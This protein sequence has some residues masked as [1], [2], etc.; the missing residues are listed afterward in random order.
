MAGERKHSDN[1]R[2]LVALHQA[3]LGVAATTEKELLTVL[4]QQLEQILK[5]V[6][7]QSMELSNKQS[8]EQ[9]MLAKQEQS[10]PLHNRNE[11]DPRGLR[12]VSTLV[13]TNNLINP[14]H[15]FSLEDLQKMAKK[16]DSQLAATNEQVKELKEKW[17]SSQQAKPASAGSKRK[18]E[19]EPLDQNEDASSK[20]RRQP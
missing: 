4:A 11:R 15:S 16:L 18:H 6:Y 19:N 8:S 12:N 3:V 5:T 7:A 14:A 10:K 17:K 1:E 13:M 2:A 9:D 20:R